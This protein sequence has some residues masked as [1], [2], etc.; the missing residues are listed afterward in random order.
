MNTNTPP[1]RIDDVMRRAPGVLATAA[2]T[3]GFGVAAVAAAT[4]GFDGAD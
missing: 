2:A 3:L 4:L 1:G